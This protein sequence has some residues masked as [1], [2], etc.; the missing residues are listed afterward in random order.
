[1][2]VVI[3]GHDYVPLDELLEAQKKLHAALALI[4]KMDAE[5]IAALTQSRIPDDSAEI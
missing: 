1:M 2:K 3:E 4:A 5:R